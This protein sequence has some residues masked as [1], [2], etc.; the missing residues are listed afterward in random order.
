MVLIIENF[1]KWI[2][3]TLTVLKCGVGG[4]WKR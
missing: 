4:R 1:R 2:R 3:N